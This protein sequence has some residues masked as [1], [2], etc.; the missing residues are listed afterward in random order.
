[1]RGLAPQGA[2]AAACLLAA[3]AD[4]Q[5]APPPPPDP[6][7]VQ[8]ATA[9]PTPLVGLGLLVAVRATG[10]DSVWI[11][12]VPPT[13]AGAP[14]TS[15]KA[16]LID[17]TATVA[18]L[19][20]LP[21]TNYK[22]VATAEGPGGT[23]DGDS[24]SF[25][26]DP[27]PYDLPQYTATGPSPAPGYVVFAAGYYG[28]VIDNSGRVVW[29]YRWPNGPGL[30]FMPLPNG[31]YAARPP[32]PDPADAEPW[33][34]IDPL[35]RIV[36]TFGCANGLNARFHDV[37]LDDSGG[38][39]LLCDETRTMDLTPYGGLADARVTGQV[40][41]LISPGLETPLFQWSVF[42][43]L[44][45]TD[46]PLAERTGATVNWTHANALALDA[47]DGHLLVSFRSLN[48]VTKVNRQTGAVIW[49]LGGLANE[50]RLEGTNM[51]PFLGQHGVRQPAPGSLLLL[52]NRGSGTRTV[53]ERYAL[54]EG[55]LTARLVATYGSAP[56]A[57]GVLGGSVQA[58]PGGRTL[59]SIG[60]G[61]RVEEFDAAGNVVWRLEGGVG[62][63]FRAQ[64]ITSLYAPGVGT[65]R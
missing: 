48:E 3:C 21:A 58:T 57:I 35:G 27:L 62:Y 11:T 55:A 41:Q 47:A 19:G 36:R 22:V 16:L 4:D 59:V 23:S 60:N 39:F 20:L 45:I 10:A 52:D 32:T 5:L 18:L 15:A 7:A 64:R 30:N 31:H 24:L 6:P 34:E 1:M 49:R 63:V 29:Y 8:A 28:I 9:T 56:D 42:D 40:V 54:D 25:A 26:T 44:A 43:H 53:A 12:A 51:P 50:F 13:G 37:I 61:E 33:V 38:Y 2:L 65:A 14:V 17:D 46:L